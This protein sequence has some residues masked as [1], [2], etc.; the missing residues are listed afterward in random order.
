MI[1]YF[2]CITENDV[3]NIVKELYA[4]YSRVEYVDRANGYARF[5]CV[6]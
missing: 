1:K 2:E 6:E 3:E 4:E 5:Y